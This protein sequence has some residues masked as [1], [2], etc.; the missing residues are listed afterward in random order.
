MFPRVSNPFV[1]SAMNATN[2]RVDLNEQSH[3]SP[4]PW[5]Y[6]PE[7]CQ[8][9]PTEGIA[10]HLWAPVLRCKL[11]ENTRRD[12]LQ[13]AEE[14]PATHSYYT[15][16]GEVRDQVDI[17]ESMNAILL[18]DSFVSSAGPDAVHEFLA[19]GD[20]ENPRRRLVSKNRTT[21]TR[22][23]VCFLMLIKQRE[24]GGFV[25]RASAHRIQADVLDHPQS[26]LVY[27]HI[28]ML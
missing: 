14:P 6:D 16:V 19:L 2:I 15:L 10:L 1:A 25:E 3:Y 17:D 22:V 8:L 23:L 12:H 18:D 27:R 28:K 13:Y 5:P 11:I 7:P 21:S 9:T 4:V 26:P 24:G 20:D